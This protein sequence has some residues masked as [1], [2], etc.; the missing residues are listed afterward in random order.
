MNNKGGKKTNKSIFLIS[1][2]IASIIITFE[3][4][5]EL[6]FSD[7]IYDSKDNL[8]VSE[9][10]IDA[11]IDDLSVELDKDLTKE[12][13]DYLLLYSILSNNNINEIDKKKIYHLISLIE[14]SKYIDKDKAY[15]DLSLL[16]IKYTNREDNVD[17][18]TLARYKF[19]DNVIEI[20]EDTINND[21]LYHELIHCVFTNE[22]TLKLP[23]FFS[24]GTTELLD[25]EYFSETPY[26][27]DRNYIYEVIL[28]KIL[29][30]LTG[31]DNVMLAYSTG[32]INYITE[33]IDEYS[34][35]DL[36]EINELFLNMD[37]IFVDENMDMDLYVKAF[38]LLDEV[39]KN[40]KGTNDFDSTNTKYLLN[41]FKDVSSKTKFLSYFN[42]LENL[43]VSTKIY[44]NSNIKKEEYDYVN[45]DSDLDE[46]YKTYSK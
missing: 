32:D 27:E 23:R 33:E 21:I 37:S 2:L 7:N 41:I 40:K 14:D 15:R 42:N 10:E 35:Y 43:G 44:F 8:K 26:L 24:E 20:Y 3:A 34:N 30:E 16:D 5:N 11:M 38:K 25:N 46:N 6:L 12:D 31:E 36:E 13:I 45:Y 39:Y 17:N 1:L 19:P 22:N 29:C 18:N 4:N 9:E 28:I